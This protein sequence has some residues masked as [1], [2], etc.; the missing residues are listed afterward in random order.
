VSIKGRL[1]IRHLK[2]AAQNLIARHEILRTT[3]QRL[4]GMTIPMQVIGEAGGIS[5]QKDNMSGLEDRDSLIEI[6]FHEASH[7]FDFKQGPILHFHLIERSK[8]DYILLLRLPAIYADSVSLRNLVGELSRSYAAAICGETLNGEVSQYADLAEWQNEL[9]E[10]EETRDGREYWH[11]QTLLRQPMPQLA[12]ECGPAI[13]ATFKPHFN[14]L[15]IA[16]PLTARIEAFARSQETS[17]GQFLLAC[18]QILLWRYTGRS[19][20]E[21]GTVFD[22]RRAAEIEGAL[23]LFAKYLPVICH[24][25]EGLQFSELLKRLDRCYRTAQDWQEY[26]SWEQIA[27]SSANGLA[28]SYLPFCFEPGPEPTSYLADGISFTIFKQYACIDC[29]KIKLSY[30]RRADGLVVEFHYNSELFRP[31][32]IRSLIGHFHT[33]LENAVTNPLAKIGELEMLADAERQQLLIEYNSTKVE[34]PQEKFA[35]ELIEEQAHCNP[36]AVAVIYEGEWLTYYELNDRAIKLANYLR[37]LEVGPE[38]VVGLCMERSL[39][40]VIS[41]LA[42]LKAGGVYLPLD[43][44]YPQARLSFMLEDARVKAL[45]TQAHLRSRL[46]QVG[47]APVIDVDAQWDFIS[48]TSAHE[49]KTMLGPDNLAYVIYTSGSTGRPK[50]VMLRHGSLKNYLL[51]AIGHYPL[52]AGCGAPVHSSLSFDL[53]ITSLFTPLL[54]GGGVHLLSTESEIEALEAALGERRGYSL[55]KLTPA[56]LQLL[57]EVL[58]EAEVE[59]AAHSLVIGGEN[60]PA[61]TVKWW[62]ERAAKTRLF[63]EYGPTESVVGCCVYEVGAQV[64]AEEGRANVPVGRPIANASLYILDGRQQPVPQGTVGE[65]YIGGEGLARGY[66]NRPDLTAERFAPSPYSEATGARLYRSGDL[67]RYLRDGQIEILGRADNQV[68]I[69]GYRIELGEIEAVL[70]EHESVKQSIVVAS[71]NERGAKRLVGYVVGPEGAAVAELKRYVRER[72]PEYMVPEAILAL[73]KMPLTANGKIDRRRLPSVKDAGRELKPEDIDARTPLEEMLIGIFE[74]VLKLDRVGRH[75]NFFEIGG[76]SLV[77]TQVISRVRAAFGVEI[78]VRSIFRDAT[79]TG[80]ARRI[81]EAIRAGEKTEAPP[82]VR[83]SREGWRGAGPPLSFAQQRL[84]FLD[85]LVPNNPLY[86]IP[87]RVRLDGRLDFDALQRVINEIVRRHEALRT[88]FEVE[89]GEPVQVID[90]WEPRRLEVTDLT[91]LPSDEQEA[92]ARRMAR[93]EAGTGFD[94]SR[95][96]LLRVKLLKLEQDNHVLLYTMHHIVSDGW[97]MEILSREVGDLYRAYSAGEASPLPELPIQ[98]ADFAVWQREWL[99]GEALERELEYWRK[100]LAGLEGLELPTDHP[101]PVAPTYRGAIQCFV[102]ERSVAERLSE[103]SRREGATLFMTLLG[104]FDVALSRYSGQED[105]TIGTDIANRNRAEIEGLIGFFV[106]QLALRVEVRTRESFRDLL[107]RVREVC[108]GAYAHQ[109]VPFEKL[110]EELQPERDLSRS[111]LFQAKLVL[112]NVPSEGLELEGLR[113]SGGGGAEVEVARSDLTLFITE[114]R[115]EGGPELIGAVNYSRDLFEAGTIERLMGHYTNVLREI[116][117]GSERRIW[118]LSLLSAEEREQIVVEWNETVRPYPSDRYVHDL[119]REQADRIPEQMALSCGREQLSYREL[120]RRANQLGNYLQGL[121]VGPEVVVG[122]C[123]KRSVEMLVAALGALKAGGAYLPLDPESP[124]ER[125][126]YM[127]EDAGVEVMMTQQELGERLPVFWGQT[128]CLDAEW[129]RISQESEREPQSGVVA[130]NLAYV[131][132]TSGSTGRPKGV[133]INHGGL[134]NY[135][136]WATEAYRIEEGEGAPVS[137]SIGFDLTVTSL[138][139][140]LVNGKR[141]DLLLEEEGIEALS[142]AL[143]RESGY[144]LVK[145]TPAHLEILAQQLADTKVEGWARA[146][147]IGGEELKSGSLKYWQERA[148]ETRL[149]NEYGPTETVVGCCV[150]EVNGNGSGTKTAPIGRPIANT[151]IYV[152]DRGLEPA[153]IGARGEIYISGAGLARGYIRKPELTG[154]KFI[155]NRFS[156]KGGERLYRTGD[157]GRYLTDGNIEFIG[158]A[159]G[160]VKVRGYRIEL[161]E[162]EATL[163]QHEAIRE[164]VVLARGDK[165]KRLIAYLAPRHGERVALSELR[166]YLKQRLPEYMTPSRYVWLEKIPVTSNGKLDRE[167]LPEADETALAREKE[168]VAP[169]GPVEEILADIWSEV[170]GIEGVGIH[171]N[172][173]ELGGHSLLLTQVASRIRSAFSLDLPLHVMFSAP[174]IKQL[175]IAI[176]AEQLMEADSTETSELLQELERLSPEDIQA[177]L[178]TEYK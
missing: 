135:L 143:R 26:F 56:H 169:S 159:D 163:L 1:K 9:I 93:E 134:A 19:E 157:L 140:P 174:T 82:L 120:N 162:I 2:S 153:P 132:Y 68:K 32:D 97:S 42:I 128:V 30:A 150:Y 110:V 43:P 124:L 178:E 102:V 118:E 95:G 152:L 3:F 101:R 5:W 75:D 62:R 114:V 90:E 70:D 172:F 15:V 166:E 115:T 138:Y 46:P 23:G 161:G 116:A 4:P 45:L 155:P 146:L 58:K 133:M 25:E 86:N 36:E 22:G 51:W 64:E 87:G 21:V 63:N 12:F 103:M 41:L 164:G 104:G 11:N 61:Q 16:A 96:P 52:D 28:A 37:V 91:N 47:Y 72:L 7:P 6:F 79:I 66:L 74:E 73:A 113:L 105:V 107:K 78:G 111:P 175:G 167:A 147:V 55:V 77:A 35:H 136:M 44:S 92:E 149:I 80:L 49:C 29:F 38:A 39:D 94:L 31:T 127:L 17:P 137:S 173:F 108:L 131:I 13:D 156:R 71:D 117:E 10:S 50:G 170:L 34:W 57:A 8:K 76:H 84:W 160:Q 123:M 119:F 158:R 33:L 24:L 139:G 141:V 130:E 168:Y 171:D 177:M 27:G 144:S 106:N 126:S 60:L 67:A 14:E 148:P 88:R 18:W 125:L 176:A 85:Q 109:D 54:V 112:Q 165:E 53:T 40:L 81:E 121:G 20:V 145:I 151:Q 69:R 100:Q 65:L 48:Q 98:Y 59:G 129:E 83:T 142:T 89:A 154:E 99:Q 122:L